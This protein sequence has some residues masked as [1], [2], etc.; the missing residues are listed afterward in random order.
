[1]SPKPTPT[2]RHSMPVGRSP[3][4]NAHAYRIDD[5]GAMAGIG[6]TTI[7]DLVKNGDLKLIKVGGRSLIDGDSLR[8]LIR[9][10]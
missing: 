2:S 3:L 9:A 8:A 4:A 10:A 7:Y 6:R 1:M 5:A